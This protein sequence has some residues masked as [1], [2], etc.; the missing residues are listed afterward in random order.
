MAWFKVD[1]KIHDHPKA[2]A[3]GKSAM[4]VWVLA[5]AWAA[6]NL[7]DGFVPKRVLSRWGTAGDAKKLVDAG[8]WFTDEEEGQPGWRFHDWEDFQPTRAQVLE[9]R[10]KNAAKLANWR[11]QKAREKE[12]ARGG[13]RAL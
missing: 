8:L 4:G 6:D 3:A 10:Q 11:A 12:Q 1:D 9:D 2:L 7:T 5:G 13:L